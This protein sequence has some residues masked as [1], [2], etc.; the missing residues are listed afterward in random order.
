M[1]V[2][3]NTII[4]RQFKYNEATLTKLLLITLKKFPQK[5][6]YIITYTPLWEVCR[7]LIWLIGSNLI[8]QLR[9]SMVQDKSIHHKLKIRVK[10]THSH[11]LNYFSNNID[12]SIMAEWYFN[13]MKVFVFTRIMKSCPFL[14]IDVIK[15]IIDCQ[16]RPLTQ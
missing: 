2:I 12:I 15:L 13:N 5:F 11:D 4:Y 6:K 10:H 7:P 16:I 14:S 8:G 3:I 1:I 9:H